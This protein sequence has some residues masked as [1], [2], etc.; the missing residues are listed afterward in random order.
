MPDDEHRHRQ[1][2]PTA[3]RV[4]ADP[5]HDR[6]ADDEPRVPSRRRRAR[7]WRR[8][9]G[10]WSAAPTASRAPP[11]SRAATLVTSTTATARASPMAPRTALRNQ[12]ERKERWESSRCAN[13]WGVDSGP[14]PA[15]GRT[16]ARRRPPRARRR[17]PSRWRCRAPGRGTRGRASRPGSR[18]STGSG[19][20]APGD[21]RHPCDAGSVSDDTSAS[22]SAPM[23]SS[24]WRVESCTARSAPGSSTGC[25][26]AVAD[27]SRRLRA[28]S[29]P[30]SA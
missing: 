10:R 1:Q 6:R 12:T 22:S 26:V 2:R 8:C 3:A 17:P 25:A 9:R 20:V 4:V 11:R 28:A 24:S 21:V 18:T 7:Q 15:A 5:D 13:T 14:S 19:R 27:Q 29:P 16:P 23:S 30:R